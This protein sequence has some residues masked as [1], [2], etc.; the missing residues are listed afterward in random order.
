MWISRGSSG[1]TPEDPRGNLDSGFTQKGNLQACRYA[2]LVMVAVA[3]AV[4]WVCEQPHSSTAPL[5][6]YMEW[7]LNLNRLNVGL[8][9]GRLVRL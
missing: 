7:V 3:R 1:R 5:L 2:M 9:A 6:P 4:Y 8:D